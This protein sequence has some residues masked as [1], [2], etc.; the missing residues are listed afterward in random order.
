MT[1]FQPPPYDRDPS[2]PRRMYSGTEL[3]PRS[4]LDR[5][6]AATLYGS[7]QEHS[8]L[9]VP[10]TR[11]TIVS[12]IDGTRTS[13]AGLRTRRYWSRRAPTRSRFSTRYGRGRRRLGDADELRGGQDLR[14]ARRKSA[15]E[16]YRDRMAH[17]EGDRRNRRREADRMP[18]SRVRRSSKCSAPASSALLTALT[19]TQR[20]AS[21]SRDR[22]SRAPSHRSPPP[23]PRRARRPGGA[24]GCGGGRAPGRT[25]ERRCGAREPALPA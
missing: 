12:A 21:P 11:T 20:S 15:A 18:Q 5:R 23:S 17:G 25:A 2:C 16:S 6:N 19:R 4:F 3:C 7:R 14:A 9:F 13:G 8:K 10:D 22:G 1:R 24:R